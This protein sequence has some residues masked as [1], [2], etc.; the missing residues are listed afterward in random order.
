MSEGAAP[1]TAA[2]VATRRYLGSKLS[3]LSGRLLNGW[4][5]VRTQPIPLVVC[6]TRTVASTSAF[7]PEKES[8]ILSWDASVGVV[9]QQVPQI[10]SLDNAG[11]SPVADSIVVSQPV[12]GTDAAHTRA[13][14]GS[15][16]SAATAGRTRSI[17]E[18]RGQGPRAVTAILRQLVRNLHRSVRGVGAQNF[19]PREGSIPFDCTTVDNFFSAQAGRRLMVTAGVVQEEYAGLPA[20]K[21]GCNFRRLPKLPASLCARRRSTNN[22][23]HV[24]VRFPSN[25]PT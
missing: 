23:L 21:R 15:I 8:S 20:R 14:D 10:L 25:A 4:A 1:A 18:T 24:R 9:Q 2:G 17:I 19:A 22:P 16:P 11:A 5:L 3:R 7:H 6:P 13:R 12:Q